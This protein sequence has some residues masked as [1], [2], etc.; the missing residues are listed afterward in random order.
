MSE[1][2]DDDPH[3]AP[4]RRP[5]SRARWLVIAG[6]ALVLLFFAVTTFASLYTD[7]LWYRSVKFESVFG[8]MFWTRA[9]LFV[10][11]GLLMVAAFTVPI[12]LAY[13]ARPF[14]HPADDQG[15][16][17][18]YREAIT[19]IKTW[20]LVGVAGIAGIFA[21]VS[22]SGEWRAYLLWRNGGSFGKDDPYFH[23]DI[24]FYVFD[25][26]WWHYLL[27]FAL[28]ALI[29]GALASIVV[30]YLY[31]GIRLGNARDRFSG[32]AVV[33]ISVLVGLV[34][35]VKAVD[36]WLDRYDLVHNAG[37]LLDGMGYTDDHAVLPAKNILMGI[38]IICALLFLANVW[39]RRWQLPAVGL[40]LFVVS[41]ILLGLIWP[42]IVQTF[43]V[44]P[45]QSDKE[46][47]Y[48][49][50]NIAAT[51]AAYGIDDANV[52]TETYA[53]TASASVTP[54]E[55]DAE[56]S[57]VPVADPNWVYSEFE[58]VQQ[59]KSYYTVAQ[60]LD[61]DR[62]KVDGHDR[63]IVLGVRELKQ[64]GISPSDRTW[65][66]LHTV[67]THSNGVVAAYANQR[68]ADNASEHPE[69]QWAEGLNNTDLT[70]VTKKFQDQVYFG[71]DS[72]DYSIVGRPKGAKAVE[73]DG[74]G[75][76]QSTTT[77]AGDGGVPIGSSFRRL[78]Y[79]IQ[80]GSA[81]FL[82]S[83]RV[84]SDSQILYNRTP[85]D[86]VEKIAPWLTLD[87]DAY[88]V[89]VDGRILWVVDG[90]TTTD[91][92][93]QSARDSFAAMTDDAMQ[94]DTGSQTVPT[95]EINYMRNAVKATVDAYDGT[96]HLYAWDDS[97]P[98]LKAWEKA[99]P[100]TVEP[101][102]DIPSALYSHLR[103]PE[104]LY[105]VQRYQLAKYHVTDAV[106]FLNANDQWTVP[107][108]P[109]IANHLQAP[110][111]MYLPAA[112][113][114]TRWS[115]TSTFTPASRQNLAAI[116]T[117]DS[118]PGTDPDHPNP[119][120]GKLR[121]LTGFGQSTQG[122]GMVSNQFR[123][124]SQIADAIARFSRSSSQA[125]WGQVLTIPTASHGLLYIEP[126]YASPLSGS[127]STY[128]RLAY[129]LV[130][131]D[132]RVGYGRT[133]SAALRS[134][135]SGTPPSGSSGSS[136]GSGG[137]GGSNGSGGNGANGGNGS[138]DQKAESQARALLSEA[139]KLFAQAETAGKDGRFED[140]ENLIKQAESKV[141][142]ALELLRK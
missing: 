109:N 98:I 42:A 52:E 112:D 67:Y 20:L 45:S 113:G 83:E 66:N 84:N 47:G 130:S 79:A 16:L 54:K 43:Q 31:G 12:V 9:G 125:A 40:A 81:N 8:T 107:E 49:A 121:I 70:G 48:L 117:V 103:Y 5:S 92:Y 24:G 76:G 27:N 134:A 32:P 128:Q 38:A 78:M 64:A 2:F 55:L 36:Y 104:D 75:A 139:Q 39:R 46:R 129:V 77:Y 141:S 82:L 126:V 95:D 115:M 93:P 56:A 90:Y 50:S 10:V 124:D 19:P 65:T 136:G 135:L 17:E 68:D 26:P 74:S 114:K 22:G 100:G 133:L 110:A 1:L 89:V 119:D 28:T 137:S 63:A 99:F 71:E 102:S 37:P 127:A 108:D 53:S 86:R 85:Q 44:K 57:S 142:Q 122:P 58:Q 123:T 73:L 131:Y 72:P 18:R 88:P 69:M 132:D 59:G 21:G 61:V 60:P 138:G 97:D 3:D 15:G 111:R 35:V 25:L 14:F 11:F 51:R 7:A 105:K 13:R 33:Q 91:R 29:L 140:R 116:M 101:K 30:H 41:A 118:D 23:K 106:A 80:F 87:D 34:L 4:P 120:Y 62:Y 96:V 94:S 6:V